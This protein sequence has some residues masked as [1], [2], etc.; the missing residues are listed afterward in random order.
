MN[1]LSFDFE[2]TRADFYA[3]EANS[4]VAVSESAFNK[5]LDQLN[6]KLDDL[7]AQLDAANLARANAQNRPLENQ[8]TPVGVDEAGE[9]STRNR[10][11]LNEAQSHKTEG[12]EGRERSGSPRSGNTSIPQS[13]LTIDNILGKDGNA[14]TQWVDPLVKT[15]ASEDLVGAPTETFRDSADIANSVGVDLSKWKLTLPVDENYFGNLTSDYKNGTAFEA[16]GAELETLELKDFF[17]HDDARGA[18]VFRADV[19]GAKTSE[20]TNYTRSELR[21]LNDDGTYAD[22]KIQ[23]G[24]ALSASLSV[25]QLASEDSGG[26]GRVIVGQIHGQDDEL[27][28]LYYDSDGRLQFANE[29]TGDDNKERLFDFENAAG[30]RVNVGLDQE[31]SYLIEV[32]D[33]KLKVA[34]TVDGEV[35][36]AVSTDGVDPTDISNAWKDDNLY[37]KAGVYQAVTN[38][39]GHVRQGSG[40]AEAAFYGID[41]GHGAS[42]GYGAWQG[43]R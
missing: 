36:N 32:K 25:S 9:I 35:F 21:E 8:N 37:F 7:N 2:K 6:V 29:I 42:A 13:I 27:V 30:E 18:T 43:A 19:D 33:E 12:P 41:V 5:K 39:D 4:D 10:R 31:F 24:G 14:A 17:F 23:E 22:W 38:E 3:E 11:G 16:K 15:F 20:R 1:D 40:T 34:I 26:A 28:R